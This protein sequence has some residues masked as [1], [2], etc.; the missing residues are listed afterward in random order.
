MMGLRLPP[1]AAITVGIAFD[2]AS[3]TNF[4]QKIESK[5]DLPVGDVLDAFSTSFDK[6][7]PQ[8]D[9]DGEDPGKQKDLGAKMAK[10]FHEKGAPGIQ[11]VSVQESFR[12][13]TDAGYALGGTFDVIQEGHIIRDQ[14]TSKAEYSEDAVQ[15]EIQPA[16]YSFAYAA[17]HGAKPQFAYDVVTKHVKEPRYQEV[18]GQVT[19]TQTEQLFDAIGIMH[20]QVRRGEFQYAPPGAWWCSKQWCGYWNMCKGK[21]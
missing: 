1:K 14:K 5:T 16:V 4:Q 11:P 12:I 15:S 18:R 10:V 2:F 7:A 19:E 9:W 20:E 8:T 6:A 3:S 21:K 17:V 13:E